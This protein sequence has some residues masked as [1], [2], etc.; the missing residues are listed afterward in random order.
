MKNT[1]WIVAL[2][3]LVACSERQSGGG[4]GAGGSS[5]SWQSRF[6]KGDSEAMKELAAK[7]P[8]ALPILE[9]LL[10]DDSETVVQNAA[11]TMGD[12]GLAAAPAVPALLE[13][14]GRFPGN[15]FVAQ[16][17][18]EL[19]TEAVPAMVK[20]LQGSNT[21]LKRE[22]A[23]IVGAT[24]VAGEPAIPALI[25]I[26]EGSDPDPVKLE[27]IGAVAAISVKVANGDALP[28]LKQIKSSGG[29]LATYAERAIRRVE[30]A[31]EYAA[32]L[33][34]EK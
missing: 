21:D 1:I 34:A 8:A 13:A 22:V 9:Q 2:L 3:C 14:M 26:L 24:G 28:I 6:A 33:A 4:G 10:Q 11:M 18:K 7:G 15:P 20:V 12:L 17:L 23:K 30:H 19:K 16:T 29:E 27:A 32:K 5:A 25:S 31:I